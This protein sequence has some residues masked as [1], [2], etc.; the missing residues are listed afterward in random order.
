MATSTA[1]DRRNIIRDL[2]TRPIGE[3]MAADQ[4]SVTSDIDSLLACTSSLEA[5]VCEVGCTI[6]TR[7]NIWPCK[8]IK[9]TRYL[10]KRPRFQD[11]R[12][13]RDNDARPDRAWY[14][15]KLATLDGCLLFLQFQ[16]D[17][18]GAFFSR[19]P[20]RESLRRV[21]CAP[22]S[23]RLSWYDKVILRAAR[24]LDAST[25]SARGGIRYA[26][27]NVDR[28][29]D[30]FREGFDAFAANVD[31]AMLRIDLGEACGIAYAR[32]YVA[33]HGLR[34]AKG[35][36]HALLHR[37]VRVDHRGLDV[38]QVHKAD[39]VRCEDE[40]AICVVKLSGGIK[41]RRSLAALYNGAIFLARNSSNDGKLLR[42]RTGFFADY[43]Y[44]RRHASPSLEKN[45]VTFVQAYNSAA[46]MAP[47]ADSGFL[48]AY[49]VAR[50][51]TGETAAAA[52]AAEGV[53][54]SR[55]MREL[56]DATRQYVRDIVSYCLN[57][58]RRNHSLRVGEVIT[59]D[60]DRLTE[61]GGIPRGLR[62]LGVFVDGTLSITTRALLQRRLLVRLSS[63]QR[64]TDRAVGSDLALLTETL[65]S[66][67]FCPSRCAWTPRYLVA[68][69]ARA[70]FKVLYFA[71]GRNAV[72]NYALMRTVFVGDSEAN[73][74]RDGVV[75]LGTVDD[76]TA[77]RQQELYLSLYSLLLGKDM[78]RTINLLAAVQNFLP[79]RYNASAHAE[80]YLVT[81]IAAWAY[82]RCLMSKRTAANVDHARLVALLAN[83]YE[84]AF[85]IER[86]AN[87]CARYTSPK[88]TAKFVRAEEADVVARAIA[89]QPPT[90]FAEIHLSS[91]RLPAAASIVESR[92]AWYRRVRRVA[93]QFQVFPLRLLSNQADYKT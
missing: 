83:R 27:Y 36:V 5:L 48:S 26:D 46:K 60:H 3:L 9:L 84:T 21:V 52:A 88:Y 70:E 20:A 49:L 73:A 77:A 8:D 63:W 39:V 19:S 78:C 13:R 28:A 92:L 51:Y 79:S 34:M 41:E 17:F 54:A 80:R 66:G 71:H 74:V 11:R 85:T 55:R 64:H 1:Q 16:P 53:G 69:A 29:Y 82:T 59:L 42:Y 38:L 6:Y 32:F 23:R 67:V 75:C 87:M 44:F 56:A 10:E 33:Q 68:R 24:M 31:L 62:N 72:F 91:I 18:E 7:P 35:P 65:H 45:A 40:D 25:E 93:R 61:N 37:I 90:T 30:I 43:G 47:T 12:Q 14:E 50:G 15:L 4:V 58:V 2:D 81:C 86:F 57:Y 76:I 89:R 22:A